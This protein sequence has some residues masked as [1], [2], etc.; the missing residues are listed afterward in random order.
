MFVFLNIVE[1]HL[2]SIEFKAVTLRKGGK[3]EEKREKK[4]SFREEDE[5][6]KEKVKFLK[7][8][9]TMKERR[10]TRYV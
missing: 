6:K 7:M 10:I 3:G 5:G 9:R 1:G 8:K 4:R 2:D